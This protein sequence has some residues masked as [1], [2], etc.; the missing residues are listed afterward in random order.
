MDQLRKIEKMIPPAGLSLFFS[1]GISRSRKT[2][3]LSVCS[4]PL[5]Q[6]KA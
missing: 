6:D 1:I 2:K 3:K 5:W 4:V